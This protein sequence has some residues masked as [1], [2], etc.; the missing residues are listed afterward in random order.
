LN[1]F[2]KVPSGKGRP[3]AR[4]LKPLIERLAGKRKKASLKQSAVKLRK[5]IQPSE[6][7]ASVK[8]VKQAS[9]QVKH[10]AK[11]IAKTIGAKNMM[12]PNS[13]KESTKRSALSTAKPGKSGPIMEPAKS[14]TVRAQVPAVSAP[15][16]P[17]KARKT[18]TALSK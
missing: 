12:K 7:I 4:R 13:G 16:L 14:S 6:P 5:I 17:K 1:V 11:P 10:S 8:Q 15:L 3:K 2:W 9:K 18:K